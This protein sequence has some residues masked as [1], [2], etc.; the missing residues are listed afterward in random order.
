MINENRSQH[1]KNIEWFSISIKNKTTKKNDIQSVSLLGHQRC[2][3][4]YGKKSLKYY[5]E[6]QFND[7]DKELNNKNENNDNIFEENNISINDIW[8]CLFKL[9]PSNFSVNNKESITEINIEMDLI[10]DIKLNFKLKFNNE[11]DYFEY[12]PNKINFKFIRKE[13]NIF[14]DI[15]EI[16]NKDLNIF[17]EHFLELRNS[18]NVKKQ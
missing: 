18:S 8:L 12:I 14:Y 3:N 6:Y 17:L 11:L 13:D 4:E 16:K 10:D 7:K 2:D 1:E 5:S 15:L 9:I